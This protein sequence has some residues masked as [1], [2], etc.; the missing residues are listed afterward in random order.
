MSLKKISN[1][2]FISYAREDLGQAKRLFGELKSAGLSP[3]LDTECLL[4]G[5]NWQVEIKSAIENSS[6]FLILVSPNSVDKKGYVDK[7]INAALSLVGQLPPSRIFVIPLHLDSNVPFIKKLKH[8]NAVNMLPSW[9]QGFG[10]VLEVIKLNERGGIQSQIKRSYSECLLF[11][12]LG[13]LSVTLPLFAYALW[14]GAKSFRDD[15]AAEFAIVLILTA[16]PMLIML[17][18][19]GGAVAQFVARKSETNNKIKAFLMGIPPVLFFLM[20][21]AGSS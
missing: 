4:P 8:I 17:P 7:E 13:G 5:Q 21:I 6:F 20:I 11:G 12:Y 3:W 9:E 18:L 1:Q 16:V 14:T 10:K 2:V 19:F 15:G